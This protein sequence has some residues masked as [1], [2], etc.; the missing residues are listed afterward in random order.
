VYTAGF[1]REPDSLYGLPIRYSSNLVA[2]SAS[3]SS[4]KII[5]VVGDFSHAIL[6]VRKDITVRFSDQA[7]IDVSGTLHHL[8][9]QNKVAALWEMRVGFVADDLNRMFVALVDAS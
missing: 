2:T 4:T 1:E 5:G 3:V 9:Q 8:W 6:G 7:T